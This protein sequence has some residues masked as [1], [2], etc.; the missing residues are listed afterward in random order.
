MSRRRSIASWI[1][2]GLALL[3]AG[4]VAAQVPAGSVPPVP[5]APTSTATPVAGAVVISP[6]DAAA[7]PWLSE[8]GPA[9]AKPIEVA[10]ERVDATWRAAKSTPHARAAALRRLRLE[11]G[12]GDLTPAAALIARH[13]DDAEE[14]ETFTGLARELAP[15]VPAF[16]LDHAIAVW[17]SGDI[18]AAVLLAG[19]AAWTIAT[20]L[21]A[22]LWLLEN[23]TF[24]L[25]LV[26]LAA[27]LAFVLLAALRVA[28]HAAHDLG[29]LFSAHMP[30]FARHALLGGLLLVPFVLGEGV[31]GF[32]LALF[33]LAFVWGDSLQRKALAMAAVLLVIGLHPLAQ[34]SSITASLMDA[35]PV[36]ASVLRVLDGTESEADVA[37]LE[38][39][40]EETLAAA[41]AL[42]Y[43]D[44]RLG[45]I[46]SSRERLEE[47]V[48]RFPSDA[49]A[50]ANL[51]NIAMRRG[52]VDTA[53]DLYE[54]AATLE[55]DPTLLFD[56]S[57][58]YA[59]AFRMEEYEATLVRAQRVGDREVAALSSL[60]DATLVADLEYPVTQL[61]SHRLLTLA[62]SAKPGNGPVARLAPGRL[63]ESWMVTGGAFALV[64]LLSILFANSWSHASL[65]VRCGHR[66]CERCEDTVWSDE[67]CEDCHHLFQ[68]PQATDPSLRMARLQALSEREV[69]FDRIWL[70]LSL[71]IPGMAGFASK[72]PDLAMFG[73]LLFFWVVAWVAWP[74]GVF[75]DPMLMGTAATVC[76]AV[77]GVL[78]AIGYGAVVV[79]SLIVRKSA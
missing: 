29:D 79:L 69:F 28:S 62:L 66:I 12:L 57:Q 34:L 9:V 37:R 48:A 39:A 59:N 73:L 18:G 27:P 67:I 14:P 72:R 38:A 16:Q 63:G 71:A 40:S 64:A 74:S 78:A 52:E 44:R 61:V 54:R 65:C 68:S 22:Q 49:V 45:L 77:P 20:S 42:A 47:I 10:A 8:E 36:A 46:E 13:A 11:A 1:L 21:D 50:R 23:V 58:A 15:G 56:L 53:I 19:R 26:V 31:L 51:G 60:D 30:G 3:L 2:I 25:L 6:E 17:R 35:D 75:A 43:R 24:V 70:T 5:V 55:S 4:P 33:T 76:L 32:A 41:H 7:D